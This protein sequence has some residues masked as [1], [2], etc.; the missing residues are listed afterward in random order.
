[1][2]KKLVIPGEFL[3]DDP[4]LADE[5][6]YVEDNKV[7]STVFGIASFKNQIR[8]VPLS[9][10]YIPKPGDLII[11]VIKE[12]T[13]SNWIV[14]IRSP[15][16]GL[17]HI[18]EFP[19]RIE[20]NEMSKYLNIGVSIMALVSDVDANMKV[21]L[22]LN[23]QRL[24][25]IKEG[26]IIEVT[27]SKVPRFIGRSGSMIAMVKN[28]T[29]CNIFIGQNGRIWITGRDND[30]QLAINSLL[31][32]EKETHISGLTDRITNFL[33]EQK[34]EK[35]QVKHPQK[36]PKTTAED[37]IEPMPVE[38]KIEES[39]EKPESEGILDE[40]LGNEK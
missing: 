7:F 16:D 39:K 13:Y 2:D 11:G 6:T 12:V 14:D 31:K 27:P 20:N 30:M 40:L 18:S 24:R 1:M 8:V 34:G 22:T 35:V 25:Q 29:K 10:K 15:Y 38:E 37:K 3:S 5:G 33:K 4:S 9:G 36:K 23:D 17:L 32:I 28:E 21:E 26:R 19:R